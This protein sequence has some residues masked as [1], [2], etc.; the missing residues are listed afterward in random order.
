MAAGA[1]PDAV[2]ARGIAADAGTSGADGVATAPD[3]LACETVPEAAAAAPRGKAVSS[4]FELST[5]SGESADAEIMEEFSRSAGRVVSAGRSE[6]SGA[7]PSCG[8]PFSLLAEFNTSPTACVRPE[9][10]VRSGLDAGIECSS[11]ATSISG[12]PPERDRRDP[13]EARNGAQ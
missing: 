3:E 6:R 9:E 2:G 5:S 13:R 12:C 4:E 1:D 11:R 7:N 8:S 10:A